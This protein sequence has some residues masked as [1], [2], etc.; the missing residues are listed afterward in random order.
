MDRDP[1]DGLKLPESASSRDRTLTIEEAR[2]I[3]LAAGR[4][5]YPARHFVQLLMLTGARRM[6]IASLR[7]EE[8]LNE[9]DG[10]AIDLPPAR[11]KINVGHHIPLSGGAL[12]VIDDARRYRVVN[13]PYVLT[14][15]GWRPFGNFGRAKIW[16]TRRLRTMAAALSRIGPSTISAA[17]SCRSWPGNLFV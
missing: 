6:E 11:T 3:Y 10:Q 16:P 9:E 13:S 7:W 4:L 2:R 8:I 12:A 17:R 15:D 14:S 5:D 1:L